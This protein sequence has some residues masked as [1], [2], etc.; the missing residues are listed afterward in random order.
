LK[1][2]E[3]EPYNVRPASDEDLHFI[4]E[5]YEHAMTRYLV[6]SVRDEATWRCDLRGRHEK[7]L[8][9]MELRIIETPEGEPVGFLA[10]HSFLWGPVMPVHQYELKPGASWVAVTPSVLRYLGKVGAE[11]EARDKKE[12]FGAFMFQLGEEHPVY[13]VMPS[14]LPRKPP[15]WLYYMRVPDLPAFVRHIAPVLERRLSASTL[16][17][18]TGELKLNFYKSTL[19]LTLDKGKLASAEPYTPEHQEDGDIFF[20]N[21]TFLHLLFGHLELEELERVYG[22]CWVKAEDEQRLL[23]K[24]LFPREGSLVMPVG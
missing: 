10:H 16:A 8:T 2:G 20:P 5:L 6:S 18:H 22:D 15:P 21:L 23:L 11:Y 3:H 9:R 13:D 17:G 12:E 4:M 19:K 24:V 1:E 14:K 7:S